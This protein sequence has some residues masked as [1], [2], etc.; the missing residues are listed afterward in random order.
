VN[1]SRPQ[2]LPDFRSWLID[3]WDFG[4]FQD[5]ANVSFAASDLPLAMDET[6]RPIDRSFDRRVLPGASLWWVTAD[7]ATLIDHA[8][9]S[10]PPTTLT[11]DLLPQPSGLAFF[12]EPLVGRDANVN[13]AERPIR[14]YAILWGDAI[15]RPDLEMLG[16]HISIASYGRLDIEA[17][18]DAVPGLTWFPL[19]RTDW[20]WRTDTEQL[21]DQSLVGQ[22]ARLASMAEDRRWFAAFCLLAGQ[23]ISQTTQVNPSRASARRSQR[24]GFD[25]TVQVVDVRH[26]RSGTPNAS[27]HREVEWSKRWVVHG[28]WRQ[29]AYGPDRSL[30]K[31]VYI[32]DFI[33]GPDDKPLVMRPKVQ[34]LAGEPQP[35]ARD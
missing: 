29:Q 11:P 7:M 33:K 25:P 12:E 14:V 2:D 24:R 6:F 3:K 8:A 15:L 22:E 20:R 32:S 31:P 1:L 35:P 30:R 17:P 27:E 21:I 18:E 5:I 16:H 4:P 19:G 26:T 13:L 10:L 9:T 34:L 28:H 23:K